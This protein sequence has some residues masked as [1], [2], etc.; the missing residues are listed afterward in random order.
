M[1]IFGTR[2]IATQEKLMQVLF[3]DD[4]LDSFC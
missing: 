3:L 1:F 4:L 2:T